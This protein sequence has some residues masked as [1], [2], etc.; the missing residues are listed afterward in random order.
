[1]LRALLRAAS[2]ADA[3]E[4]A[5]E[6]TGMLS[7]AGYLG[8]PAELVA[9]RI[10]RDTKDI[11]YSRY[12]AS[13]PWRSH[14]A[15]IFSQ[16]LRWGQVDRSTALDRAIECYRPDLFRAAAT[17]IGLS[18]PLIDSKVEGLNDAPWV[19]PGSRGP[20]PMAA[21]K[22]FDGS[23]FDPDSLL[24]YAAGFAITRLND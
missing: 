18:T 17:E 4:N 15:W 5:A 3:V 8:A 21:D 2:W 11:R 12:A 22:F 10:G 14:A 24:K 9:K 20:I 7:A 16:M 1:L 19:L 23:R 6:M 13:F